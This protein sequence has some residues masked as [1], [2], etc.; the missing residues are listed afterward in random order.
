MAEAEHSDVLW[1]KLNGSDPDTVTLF[2]SLG[3]SKVPLFHVVQDGQLVAELTASL[4][5]EKLA[6][7]RRE[8]AK[9]KHAMASSSPSPPSS[10]ASPHPGAQ[11]GVGPHSA[12]EP[13]AAVSC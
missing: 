9:H 7:F 3:V 4:S 13:A 8:L 2:Q 11:A 5:P 10:A 1:A 6:A 12:C